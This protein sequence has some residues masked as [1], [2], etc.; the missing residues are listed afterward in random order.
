[1][2]DI[3]RANFVHAD[4]AGEDF[5][6]AAAVSKNHWPSCFISGIET[7]SRPRD[8]QRDLGI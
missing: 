5:L 3:D 8:L 7:A 6:F 2:A 1:M 4:A